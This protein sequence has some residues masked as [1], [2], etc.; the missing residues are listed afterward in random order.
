MS[1]EDK[2][3]VDASQPA[4]LIDGDKSIECPTLGEA[5]VALDHLPEPRQ[6]AATIKIGGRVFTA[7]E[8]DWR[9]PMMLM[10][11]SPKRG[12]PRCFLISLLRSSS[13]VVMAVPPR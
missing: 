5:V 7:S 1:S 9:A 4:T 10:K 11:S 12:V 8:I 6:S 2:I 13:K 3:Y